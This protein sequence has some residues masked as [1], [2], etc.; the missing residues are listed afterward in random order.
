MTEAKNEGI[1]FQSL[2]FCFKET[3][4]FMTETLESSI[5]QFCISL[6]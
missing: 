5:S 6:T 4:N 1:C 3:F 2:F